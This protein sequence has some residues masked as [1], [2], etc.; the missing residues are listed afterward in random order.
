MTTEEAKRPRGRPRPEATILRDE[1]ILSYLRTEGDKTRNQI[2]D[3]L[4]LDKTLTYLAL[5]R[6]RN[7]GLAWIKGKGSGPG[8]I[9]TTKKEDE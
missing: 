9:W 8:A 7:A 2:A 3:E 4:G 5:D 6:L 1:R